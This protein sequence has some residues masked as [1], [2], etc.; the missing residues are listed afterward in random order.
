MKGNIFNI[1]VRYKKT[2][3]I[4]AGDKKGIRQ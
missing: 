2:L 4:K 1:I 3:R